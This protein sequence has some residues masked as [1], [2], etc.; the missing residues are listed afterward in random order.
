MF[1]KKDW[2]WRNVMNE[3]LDIYDA[4]MNHIGT[5]SRE[6]AHKFGY[7]HQTFHCWIVR[8][9]KGKNYVLFQIRDMMMQSKFIGAGAAAQMDSNMAVGAD[10]VVTFLAVH[11]G[12]AAVIL[13]VALFTGLIGKIFHMAFKQKNELGMMMAC[14]SGMVFFVL[15]VLYFMENT[16]LLPIMSSELPFFTAGASN[17]AVSFMLAGIVLSVYRFKSVL[18][19]TFRTV[20][21]GKA[22]GRLKVSISWEKR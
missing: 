14:G 15:T 12:Y 9:E 11:F 1:V 21:K 17:M 8:R 10:Y 5:A 13:M 18:P 4:K 16:S 19:K 20:Q 7:W 22:S 6:E 2:K 3:I